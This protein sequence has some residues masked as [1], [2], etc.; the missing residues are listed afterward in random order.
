LSSRVGCC[1]SNL[2]EDNLEDYQRN[3]G[4]RAALIFEFRTAIVAQH[5]TTPIERAVPPTEDCPRFSRPAWS[6]LTRVLSGRL[7]SIACGLPSTLV[8]P[9]ESGSCLTITI[10]MTRMNG[11]YSILCSTQPDVQ[12]RLEDDSALSAVPPPLASKGWCQDAAGGWQ[13]HIS[14]AIP[15]SSFKSLSP[16]YNMALF[17]PVRFFAVAGNLRSG[18]GRLRT[19]FSSTTTGIS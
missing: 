2:C 10:F 17:F 18:Q 14:I 8:I 13:A 3:T 6:G 1:K 5:Q 16:R 9:V 12:I 19:G 4:L 11:L 7:T 15:L